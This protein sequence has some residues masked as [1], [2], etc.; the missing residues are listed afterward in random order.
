MIAEEQWEVGGGQPWGFA[1]G[2]AVEFKERNVWLTREALATE[3]M[4]VFFPFQ[5]RTPLR[6]H[7][8]E[9]VN[10]PNWCLNVCVRG[11]KG[12]KRLQ[13][14]VLVFCFM[15]RQTS[16]LIR[17]ITKEVAQIHTFCHI[18]HRWWH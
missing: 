10:F 13:K 16:S 3:G 8:T 15:L 18:Q 9:G 2:F 7:V 6:A 5:P 17:L 12:A 14:N 4:G 11:G 1:D